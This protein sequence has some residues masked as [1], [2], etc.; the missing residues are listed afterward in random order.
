MARHVLYPDKRISQANV[1][2][3]WGG[4]RGGWLGAENRLVDTHLRRSYHRYGG[5][6]IWLSGI[7]RFEAGQR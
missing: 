7:S 6:R 5:N 4:Q 3:T 2:S 1:I